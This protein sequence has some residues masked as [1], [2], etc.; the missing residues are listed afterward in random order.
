MLPAAYSGNTLFLFA[1]LKRAVMVTC[2]LAFVLLSATQSLAQEKESRPLEQKR[3]A[4]PVDG[5]VDDVLR[6][7]TDLVAVDVRVTDREGR[8]VRNLKPE[9]F[10][11]YEDSSE[12]TISFFKVERKNG[13]QQP[14]AVVFALDISGSMSREE[15]ERLR[16][17]MSVFSS[18]LAERPRYFRVRLRHER[19]VLQLY[20]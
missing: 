3:Q 13:D 18:W 11:L 17:A 5:R 7:D 16:T 10:K 9:D 14:V 8:P 6:I 20:K 15:M 1:W 12:R 19:R 2:C 4:F